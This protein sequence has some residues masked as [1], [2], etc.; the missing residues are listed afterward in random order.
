MTGPTIVWQ[1][2]PDVVGRRRLR[3]RVRFG[4][5]AVAVLGVAAGWTVAGL[6]GGFV[7]LLVMLTVTLLVEAWARSAPEAGVQ[8]IWLDQGELCVEGPEVFRRAAD[9]DG[10]EVDPLPDGAGDPGAIEALPVVAL[11][12]VTAA[13]VYPSTTKDSSGAG[14]G[15]HHHLVVDLELGDASRCCV[16]FDRRIP[17]RI[18]GERSLVEAVRRLVGDRWRDRPGEPFGEIDR[19]RLS[20]WRSTDG[21]R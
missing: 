9:D 7:A 5:L 6:A 10:F 15:T 12:D 18:A 3:T 1:F 4:V 8:R 19:R 2:V 11:V 20:D 21:D 16:V 17:F 14:P 13:S